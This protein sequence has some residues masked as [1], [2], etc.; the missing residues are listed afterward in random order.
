MLHRQKRISDPAANEGG[1]H[2]QSFNKS[3]PRA[4]Y[5]LVGFR[6]ACGAGGI[7]PCIDQYGTGAEAFAKHHRLSAQHR[8]EDAL[9]VR[10]NVHLT[11]WQ[12]VQD[13]SCGGGLLQGQQSLHYSLQLTVLN[14]AVDED[15]GGVG[16]SHHQTPFHN[17][18]ALV[19]AQAL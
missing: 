12:T 13:L 14:E 9:G 1:V 6:L 15:K 8:L 7:G 4:V 17:V 11:V 19:N 2:N 18:E 5:H 3:V 16:A 10:G